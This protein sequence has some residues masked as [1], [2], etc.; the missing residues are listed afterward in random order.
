M[1]YFFI[2]YALLAVLVVSIGGFRGEK[3]KQTPIRIFPDMDEQDRIDPQEGSDFFHDGLGARQPVQSTL[4]QG[5]EPADL[6]DENTKTFTNDNSYYHTGMFDENV[7]GNGLPVE[8]LG[9]NEE[10]LPAFIKRGKV[11]FNSNCAICHGV[12][13]NGKGVVASYG[14]PGVFNL[15][16]STLPDGGMYDVIVNGRGNMAAF[17]YQIDV[18]DR[19]AIIA[20]LRALQYARK[21]PLEQVKD[22]YEASAAK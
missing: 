16:D 22:A 21:A 10:N 9:L 2:I 18:K 4:P 3:F 7:F 12:S 13:G 19:W 8:E 11:A 5:L 15:I 1:R 14:V 17:G 6:A 20:Y